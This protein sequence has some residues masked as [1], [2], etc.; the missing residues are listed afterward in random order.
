M[1]ARAARGEQSAKEAVAEAEA[2]IKPIFEQWRAEGPGR[3][4]RRRASTMAIVE[5]RDL[6]KR[7]DG[8]RRGRW[9]QSGH[10]RGRIPGPAGAL[11]LRQDHAAAHDRRAGTAH[12]GEIFIGGNVTDLPPRARQIAMVFQSY[13]LYPHMTVGT[14]SP[15]RS[16]PQNVEPREQ[17]RSPGPRSSWGSRRSLD[18]KPRQLSGGQR[19]RVAL[20]RALVR[21]PDVFL[22]DE[23]LSNL[24]AKRRASA[25]DELAV[26]AADRHHHHLRHPRPGR[27]HGHGRP[28]RGPATG[29]IRQLGTPDEIYDDPADTFVATFLGSPPMNLVERDDVL[30][31]F[32]PRTCCPRRPRLDGRGRRHRKFAV[33]R[34]EYLGPERHL[35]GPSRDSAPTPGSSPL[36]STV[37]GGGRRS[38]RRR[39][40]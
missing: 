16:R 31:G 7:F 12:A 14:T 38:A 33:H 18:R 23:P 24:D 35:Y 1:M 29:R 11:G 32:R 5:V 6:A 39:S 17:R 25:R 30:L 9:H 4:R 21:E 3:R 20:A 22:L 26:P 40:S 10:R 2:E 13:A 15:S 27:G 28:H 19:Q 37:L 8:R 34:V 36:P